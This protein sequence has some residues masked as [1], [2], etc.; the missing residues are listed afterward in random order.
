[1]RMLGRLAIAAGAT[2]V[3]LLAA[4]AANA[5][6]DFK[7]LKQL[8]KSVSQDKAKATPRLPAVGGLKLPIV[9]ELFGGL[10]GGVGGGV[11]NG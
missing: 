7:E 4:P 11:N 2:A 9:S 3:V 8:S 6:P 1:M 5:D 10:L